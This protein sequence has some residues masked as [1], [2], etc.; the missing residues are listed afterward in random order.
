M[1]K[2]VITTAV[3]LILVP[4]AIAADARETST[5]I[6]V[7]RKLPDNVTTINLKIEA[8]EDFQGVT[9]GMFAHNQQSLQ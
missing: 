8:D 4:A 9:L 2:T 6:P 1:F 7:A 5:W 3:L